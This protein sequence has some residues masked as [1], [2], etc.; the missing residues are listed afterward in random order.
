MRASLPKYKVLYQASQ[1]DTLDRDA[2]IKLLASS[3]P[4]DQGH[5]VDLSANAQWVISI[6]LYRA[7]ASMAILPNAEWEELKK[8]NVPALMEVGMK[9]QAEEGEGRGGRV[10]VGTASQGAQ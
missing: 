3:V 6:R 1:H 7:T 5:I 10:V 2:L 4:S 8:F 9:K